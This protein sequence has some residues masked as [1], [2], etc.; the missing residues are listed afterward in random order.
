M[1]KYSLLFIALFVFSG[2][3]FGQSVSPSIV[4]NQDKQSEYYGFLVVKHLPVNVIK[5][6]KTKELKDKD[7]KKIFPVYT[8]GA[9]PT[10]PSKPSILGTYSIKG[11]QIHFKPRF[12]WVEDLKY[13]AELRFND[14]FAQV[15]ESNPYK[16]KRIALSF[17]LAKEQRPA[18]YVTKVYPQSEQLPANLLKMY[19]YFSAPMS[20]R[21]SKKYVKVLDERGAVVPHVFL[22]IQ[23]E[24]WNANRT[25]LTLFFDPGR[26]KR[27][28][29]PHNENGVPLQPNRKYRLVI[30]AQWKDVFG[31][32]LQKRFV[33]Q[34]QT[35]KDDRIQPQVNQW[36]LKIPEALT[37]KPLMIDAHNPMDHALVQRYLIVK[38]Q[39]GGEVEGRFTL[40]K[41]DQTIQFFPEKPWKPGS[42]I[43]QIDSRLEDL[44]GNN[45]RQLFDVDMQSQKARKTYKNS[46]ELTFNIAKPANN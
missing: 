27:G 28:L 32:P 17:Q 11:S 14:L 8:G 4:F 12:F 10:D 16:K 21:Q 38:R 24:L 3:A 35:I 36:Q 39:N 44:A 2:I 5:R 33:K 42:Y 43:I 18:T 26:I 6:L 41:D 22:P 37:Q 9:R 7:W 45:L 29:R 19:I 46:A 40:G 23:E 30:D 20:R 13:Y 25:R 34:F 15:K 1:K 31:N